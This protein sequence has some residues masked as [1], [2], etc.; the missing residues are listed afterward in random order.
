MYQKIPTQT[1]LE[2]N[3]HIDKK[4]LEQNYTSKTFFSP[5]KS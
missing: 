1:Q 2:N 5:K 4:K 3:H